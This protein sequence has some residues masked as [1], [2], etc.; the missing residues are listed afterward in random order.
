MCIIGSRRKRKESVI[1]TRSITVALKTRTAVVA[2]A[3]NVETEAVTNL[4][5]TGMMIRRRK[6]GRK[7]RP[8]SQISL[9]IAYIL[10]HFFQSILPHVSPLV[11]D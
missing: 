7:R 10:I 8:A 6:E 4:T 3:Y 11:Q 9:I 1:T 2:A 5:R